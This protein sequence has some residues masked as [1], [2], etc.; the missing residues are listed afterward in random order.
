MQAASC[1]VLYC[2][3]MDH[4]CTPPS[5]CVVCPILCL[6]QRHN[7]LCAHQAQI[8]DL[9]VYKNMGTNDKIPAG[10]PADLCRMVNSFIDGFTGGYSEAPTAAPTEKHE[11]ITKGADPLDPLAY[12]K[13]DLPNATRYVPPAAG[14][15]TDAL[16]DTTTDATTVD[17]LEDLLL[18]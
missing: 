13:Y 16:V 5:A 3:G 9:P 6:Q 2:A 14:N 18:P 10:P 8:E 12:T 17:L 1:P 7:T 4:V 11:D 15:S